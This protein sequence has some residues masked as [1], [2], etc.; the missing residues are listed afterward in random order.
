M[1]QSQLS[2][3]ISSD[4][5][6]LRYMEPA[7]KKQRTEHV[8]SQNHSYDGSWQHNGHHFGTQVFNYAANERVEDLILRHLEYPEMHDRKARIPESARNTFS[9]IL[10]PGADFRDWLRAEQDENFFWIAGKAGS[11][12]STLMKY[13]YDEPRLRQALKKWTDG[14]QLITAQHFFWYP[15]SPIQ[16]SVLGL[17]QS[18]LHQ[19]CNAQPR[20]IEIV[21]PERSK[22]ESPTAKAWTTKELWNGLSNL[23]NVSCG[24]RI[25]LFV[26][27]LD[28][29]DPQ[30]EHASFA[31]DLLALSSRGN[32]KICVSS[33]PWPAFEAVFTKVKN[34]LLLEQLTYQDLKTFS[35]EALTE[36]LGVCSLDQ[37]E[38]DMLGTRVAKSAHGVF[39]W[40]R[41][42]VSSMRERGMAGESYCQ[43]K[44]CLEEFPEDLED[45]FRLMIYD[46]IHTTWR[47][48]HATAK[49]LRLALELQ[50]LQGT[51]QGDQEHQWDRR[52][53]RVQSWAQLYLHWRN[54]YILLESSHAVSYSS[55][56]A[57]SIGRTGFH[58]ASRL[59]KNLQTKI[60]AITGGLLRSHGDQV[61]FMHRTVFD[62]LRT[63]QIQ[64]LLEDNLPGWC[65]DPCFAKR[66]LV[67][68]CNWY[69]D[70]SSTKDLYHHIQILLEAMRGWIHSDDSERISGNA[71]DANTDISVT[72][73]G[74]AN[75]SANRRDNE[76][77]DVDDT[78]DTDGVYEAP[79]LA[80]S[81]H[82]IDSSTGDHG[83][84]SVAETGCAR[85]GI[86]TEAH[87]IQD[88]LNAA[89]AL[90]MVAMNLFKLHY[91]STKLKHLEVDGSR[92]EQK[93]IVEIMPI[94][95]VLEIFCEE[96]SLMKFAMLALDK[97]PMLSVGTW[98]IWKA[99][100]AIEDDFTPETHNLQYLERL[101]A[102]G[103]DPR[104][105][106][107]FWYKF[108]ETWG[109]ISSKMLSSAGSN[110]E[111]CGGQRMRFLWS[112]AK[113]LILHGAPT[114]PHRPCDREGHRQF[115]RSPPT[116]L[117]QCVPTECEDELEDLL[118]A[119]SDRKFAQSV[120]AR[121][122]QLR[123][124][125]W[126]PLVFIDTEI[127]KPVRANAVWLGDLKAKNHSISGAGSERWVL[128]VRPDVHSI[129]GNLFYYTS[130]DLKLIICTLPSQKDDRA[131]QTGDRDFTFDGYDNR[132]DYYTGENLPDVYE[133]HKA[134]AMY[135]PSAM[136]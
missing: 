92:E 31:K 63:T 105:A 79:D 5:E 83:E 97:W 30:D 104:V 69:Q 102:H 124:D 26:D 78:S 11:G 116:L 35:V 40:A 130:R 9:W 67:A 51:H 71:Q 81:A 56:H 100:L 58:D 93:L 29:Y 66:V 135:F 107:D 53:Q 126:S 52:D 131:F 73:S 84:Q 110:D 23:Q 72:G 18:L 24:A 96:Y 4:L 42:V 94:L 108:L 86:H 60:A 45:Y 136:E 118:L 20:L 55:T 115:L 10:E 21:F 113:S 37:Q 48:G 125:T 122:T 32:L 12:K 38:I 132:G 128:G 62:F 68:R 117:R 98:R 17:L 114:T 85:G 133:K 103:A 54:Y 33:R 91:E 46:R 77:G 95:Q 129:D 76:V 112:K 80:Y 121:R 44:A 61:E 8:W 106:S 87:T 6:T 99:V 2:D 28:E 19:I 101:L 82:N 25:C 57:L 27:G 22:S 34:R 49:A 16:K 14:Q 119:C 127:P 120:H 88:T 89:N 109:D 1:C 13:L 70:P 64:I 75:I 123:Q 65:R 43:L 3:N 50:L 59:Q 134:W 39:L 111:G 7:S 41:L 36:V 90:E 47:Q 74:P 15:G